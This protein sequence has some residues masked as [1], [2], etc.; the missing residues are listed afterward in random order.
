[1][2]ALPFLGAIVNQAWDRNKYDHEAE[3]EALHYS[4]QNLSYIKPGGCKIVTKQEKN[5]SLH[6][7]ACKQADGSWK[8]SEPSYVLKPFEW[9][10]YSE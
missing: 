4:R 3:M 7:E 1:M 2:F 9:N 8:L 6:R 10:I 5:A